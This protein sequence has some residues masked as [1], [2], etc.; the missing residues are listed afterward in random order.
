MASTIKVLGIRPNH[1]IHGLD[2]KSSIS[3]INGM[4]FGVKESRRTASLGSN[5]IKKF[6]YC[7]GINEGEI[8]EHLEALWDDGFGPQSMRDYFDYARD[9]IRNDGGP[10]RWFTPLSCG[11]PLK[12]S[13]LLLFLPGIDGLGLGL[14]MHHQSLGKVFHVRCMHIPVH[15]RKPFQ[16]LVEWVEGTLKFEH[17]VSPNKPV[18]IVGDSSGGCLALAVAARN[19]QIDLVLILANPATSFERSRLPLFLHSLETLPDDFHATV[20]Y[21]LGLILV[22]DPLKMVKVNI[23]NPVQ[24]PMQYFKQ[25]AGNIAA[26]QPWL[27]DLAEILPKETLVWRLKQLK[28]AAAYANSRLHAVKAQ[29][30]VLAS[31]K[32]DMLP[33]GEEAWRI[34]RSIQNCEIRCFKDKRHNILME[35]GFNLLTIIKATGTYRRTKNHDLVVDFLPPSIS[36]FKQLIESSRWY[37][38][39]TSPVM[40]ST[41]EDGTIVR[42]LSGVP[43]H[44]PVLLVGNHML[45]GLEIF[46]LVA[47]FLREMRIMVRGIAHP[48]LFSH[49]LEGETKESSV[50][51][52]VR[53]YGA[54]C[55][56]P[57]NLFKLLR[58]KSHVLLYPGGAREALHRKGEEYKL[59]WPEEPEFV[60]MAARFGATIVPFGGIGED[61]IA[62]IVLD[63]DDLMKV[64]VLSDS[65]R[66][67]NKRYSSFNVRDGMAGEVGN[68][69]LYLPAL[70]P[71]IPAGR[72]Y[73]LF[74]KPIRTMGRDEVL[75]DRQQARLVYLQVKSEV[76]TNLSY[77]QKKRNE[78]PYRSIIDRIVYQGQAP[79]PSIDQIPSFEL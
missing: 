78:D 18:Y 19:P 43:R 26:L 68:Q 50:C 34:L 30:L 71:K 15:D 69:P 38:N 32:D 16:E 23:S 22:V 1:I 36:E 76:E 40:L 3:Q 29:V 44:G 21:L 25:L 60:R 31:G 57:S 12:D 2:F 70:L 64:P 42:G 13:P 46:P 52:F 20:P 72:L 17:S 28:Q 48:T 14:I 37:H 7:E 75:K 39:Y 6:A 79:W 62:K 74:G 4:C 45:M 33:S 49:F 47:E 11:P 27:R 5:K 35:D 24:H 56:S 51:D 65:I 73:Y 63:Y 8:E 10:P 59:F 61:D 41:M 9:L 67:N 54:L 77:L 58:M 55:V 66:R 53:L